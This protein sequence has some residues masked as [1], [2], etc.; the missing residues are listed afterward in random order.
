MTENKFKELVWEEN[1]GAH[2]SSGAYTL[3]KFDDG[4][5]VDFDD[6]SL[7]HGFTLEE[8]KQKANS[9]CAQE[10]SFVT[11][12]YKDPL[13]VG[14]LFQDAITSCHLKALM[15]MATNGEGSLTKEEITMNATLI[16]YYQEKA[17]AYEEMRDNS[18]WSLEK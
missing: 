3:I 11:I 7:G 18:Q 14:Y 8:A 15:L 1:G 12:K 4:F 9:H 6:L 2:Y 5:L 13:M 16:V 17:A 10:Q